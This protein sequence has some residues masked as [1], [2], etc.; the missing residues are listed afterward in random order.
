[1]STRIS[2]AKRSRAYAHMQPNA[3]GFGQQPGAGKL[4]FTLT[5]ACAQ[6]LTIQHTATAVVVRISNTESCRLAYPH[7]SHKPVK[8]RSLL[9]ALNARKLQKQQRVGLPIMLAR[10]CACKPPF[11]L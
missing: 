11:S 9:V 4:P 2:M 8:S 5:C 3:M 7:A 6:H 1:M 10:I